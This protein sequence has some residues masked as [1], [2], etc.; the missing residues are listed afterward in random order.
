MRNPG[1]EIEPQLAGVEQCLGEE[2]TTRG[3]A[4][5]LTLRR[6]PSYRR[7]VPGP[8][9]IGKEDPLPSTTSGWTFI[10]IG[11]VLIVV[12]LL[13]G[14][15]YSRWLSVVGLAIGGGLVIVGLRRRRQAMALP[16]A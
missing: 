13:L 12:A 5:R 2:I 8:R 4:D 15:D 14:Q 10:V 1:A 16:D 6:P 11:L 9:R 7:P 3:P